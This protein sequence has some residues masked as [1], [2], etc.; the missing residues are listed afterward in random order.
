MT[1]HD[2]NGELHQKITDLDEQLLI[3]T[4]TLDKMMAKMDAIEQA[5][6]EMRKLIQADIY[7][8]LDTK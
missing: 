2:E 5:T 6:V 4:R 3:L 8:G 1:Q 7:K